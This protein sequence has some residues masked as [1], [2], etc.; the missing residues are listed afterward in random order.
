MSGLLS[1]ISDDAG[2]GNPLGFA[3]K[4]GHGLPLQSQVDLLDQY[5]KWTLYGVKN[6]TA[7]PPLKSL[8][9]YD[10]SGAF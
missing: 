5:I 6:D 10:F 8:V 2:G 4:V 3:M 7:L 9:V 1:G